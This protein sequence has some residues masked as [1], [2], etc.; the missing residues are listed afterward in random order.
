MADRALIAV[1][2]G[3]REVQ[4]RAGVVVG[5]PL[6]RPLLDSVSQAG[7]LTPVKEYPGRSR[8]SPSI[9]C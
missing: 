9:V 4:R 5:V 8:P 2:G 3:D 1:G 7:R 6:S